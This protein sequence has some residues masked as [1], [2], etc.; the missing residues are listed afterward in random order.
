[1]CLC[2]ARVGAARTAWCVLE[3]IYRCLFVNINV[4]VKFFLNIREAD[5]ERKLV[6]GRQRLHK[7]SEVFAL[8]HGL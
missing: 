4:P 7:R 8:D 1:M 6:F 3:R 2:I 5:F